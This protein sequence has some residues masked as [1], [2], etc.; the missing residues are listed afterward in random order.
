MILSSAIRAY[1]CAEP[2]DMR[3]SI[4]GLASLVDPLLGMNALSGQ[5]FVF[6]G[7][8]RD[9]EPQVLGQAFHPVQFGSLRTRRSAS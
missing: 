7:K 9:H 4:D 1:V 2:I 5:V 8:R 6:I 3:K